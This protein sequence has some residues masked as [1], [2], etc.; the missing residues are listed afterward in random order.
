MTGRVLTLRSLAPRA[1]NSTSAA[2]RIST[3]ARCC[4]ICV[5]K[6]R[7]VVIATSRPLMTHIAQHRASVLIR[8]AAEVEFFALGAS[9]R[10]VST[11]PVIGYFGAIAEWFAIEWIEHCAAAHPEWEFRLIGRIDG[12]DTGRVGELPNVRFY[13]EQPYEELPQLLREFDVA[14]IPFKLID[15]TR[16]TN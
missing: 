9:D 11:R 8:N 1:K 10:K 4:A 16:C 13:G 15:L 5:I 2:F 6:G 12:C 14:L 7:D 3:L